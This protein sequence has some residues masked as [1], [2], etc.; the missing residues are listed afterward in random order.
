MPLRVYDQLRQQ[1]FMGASIVN[2]SA[3]LGINGSPSTLN[4][5]LIEDLR[6]NTLPPH[7]TDPAF[8][9]ETGCLS[10]PGHAWIT[11]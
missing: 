10:V 3:N 6:N 5:N 8:I 1:T 11:D 2:F 7:C 9:S 4:V